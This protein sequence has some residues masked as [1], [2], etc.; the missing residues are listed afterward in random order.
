MKLRTARAETYWKTFFLTSVTQRG[1]S[2]L[3]C[4]DVEPLRSLGE[5]PRAGRPPNWLARRARDKRTEFHFKPGDLTFKRRALGGS[6]M[7][8]D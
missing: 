3:V 7:I 6:I 8:H 5:C 1:R 4:G 2:K